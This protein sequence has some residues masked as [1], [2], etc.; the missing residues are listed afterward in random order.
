VVIFLN[1]IRSEVRA[2]FTILDNF[3]AATGLKLN[4]EKCTVA[5]IFRPKVVDPAC[6]ESIKR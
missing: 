5:P 3:G 2:L 6:I 4:V 1:P